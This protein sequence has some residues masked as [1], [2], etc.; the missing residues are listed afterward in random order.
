MSQVT[1]STRTTSMQ[2]G[3]QLLAGLRRTQSGLARIERQISTGKA[4]ER[5]SDAPE[6]VAAILLLETRLEGRAQ[7]ESNANRGVAVMNTVDVALA[8]VTDILL[9]SRSIAAS[10][11]GLTSDADTRRLEAGVI[12]AQIR[13]LIDI[14]NRQSQDVALFGGN[15]SFGRGHNVFE[16]FLGGVRYRGAAENLTGDFGFAH[17]FDFNSNGADAFGALSTR[18]EG[19]VDLAPQLQAGTLLRDLEGALGKGVRT[20]AVDLVVD[21]TAVSVDLT[22]ADTANDVLIRV[23]N[24]ITTIDPTAGNFSINAGRFELTANAGHAISIADAT[25]G[26]TASDLGIIFSAAGSTVVGGDVSPKLTG[27]TLL[28]SF[29]ATVD[30]ASGIEITNGATTKVADFSA[31][32]T[33]QEMINI[34]G[35]MEMGVRLEINDSETGF[36]LISEVSGI[37]LSLGEN[38][39]T[40]ATDL[41]LRSFGQQTRLEDF[42][43]GLGV[44]VQAGVDDFS[45]ELHDGTTFNVNLDNAQNV[46]DVISLINAAATSAGLTVGVPGNGASDFNVGLAPSGNGFV[47]EDNTAGA[48]SFRVAQLGASLAAM[49]LGIYQDAGAG[50]SI[51]GED[52]ALVRTES[53]FTHLINFRDSLLSNDSLGITLAGEGIE[54]DVDVVALERAKVGV[55]TRRLEDQLERLQEVQISEKNTLSELQDADLTA[56]ITRMTQLQAQLQASMQVGLQG[57]Q[58]SLLDFLQ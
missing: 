53:V 52:N 55:N 51:N 32:T 35:E 13:G 26:A 49:H 36:N 19:V 33:V 27:R 46:G 11:I 28:S 7:E 50:T 48:G 25:T 12:D 44:E 39:G 3:D 4:V 42:R 56:V 30:F 1:F 21:G 16:E 23:N 15:I 2:Q 40:T 31:A 47:F 57:L 8:D 22:S 10:Q 17:A 14:A 9:E 5:P 45:M 29:G 38:G 54:K 20:G 6:K 18:V 43:F 37:A 58:L 41:G 24:A 34:V